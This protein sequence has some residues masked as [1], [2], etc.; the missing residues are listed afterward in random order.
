MMAQ[1]KSCYDLRWLFLT[2]IVDVCKRPKICSS[3]F[4]PPGVNVVS[5]SKHPIS[6]NLPAPASLLSPADNRDKEPEV[7]LVVDVSGA[8]V[9]W[10]AGSD[11]AASRNDAAPPAPVVAVVGGHAKTIHALG[12]GGAG[13]ARPA[14]CLTASSN[15]IRCSSSTD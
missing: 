2:C 15:S 3:S 10:E 1:C 11:V 9:T 13:V 5:T 8:A 4:T 6:G 14:C 12:E 7:P